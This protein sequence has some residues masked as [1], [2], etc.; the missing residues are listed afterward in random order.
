M[1]YELDI[2]ETIIQSAI[3][4][5]GISKKQ[6]SA[7]DERIYAESE[8]IKKAFINKTFRLKKDKYI[9]VYIQNHQSA[10][11]RLINKVFQ[12][13]KHSEI[14][15]ISV[16]VREF[17]LLCLQKTICYNLEDILSF[18]ESN[19][20]LYFNHNATIPECCRLLAKKN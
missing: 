19:F 3:E 8:R 18:I 4:S 9:K 16:G 12:H 17:T 2:L 6:F 13:S 15:K 1:K 10:L 5:K 14:N 7:Y 20:H 11:I